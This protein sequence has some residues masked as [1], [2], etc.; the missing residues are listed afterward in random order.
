MRVYEYAKEYS[1]TA[2]QLIEDLAQGGFA[3]KSHMSVLEDEH[4]VY[5]DKKYKQVSTK[6]ELAK[7]EAVPVKKQE[8]SQNIE[9]KEPEKE[10]VFSKTVPSESIPKK[11]T[12][13]LKS[14]IIESMSVADVAQKTDL[15]VNEVILTLLRWGV[16]AT[17]NQVL[18]EDVVQRLAE[19]YQIEP[20]KP[21]I[22]EKEEIVHDVAVEGA[23][24]KERL[25]II[26]VLG[27]VDHGKTTLLDFI[28][29]TRVTSR[30]KGGITQHLGAYEATTKHGNLI[31]LDT[32]GHEAFSNI[33]KRGVK[34]A[35]IAILIVAADDGIM[36]QTIEAIKFAKSMEVPIIVAINKIDKAEKAQIEVVKRELSQHDLLP[37]EWGGD[38]VCLPISAKNGTGVDELLEMLV[39]QS[40]MMELKADVA[41]SAKGYVLESKLEK[42]RGAVATIICRHGKIKIGDYFIAGNTTGR[43]S[44]MVDSLGKRVQKAGPSIPVQVAGFSS[45]PKAGV[46]FEV[47]SKEDYRKARLSSTSRKSLAARSVFQEN[48]INLLVKTDNDSSKEALFNSINKLSKKQEKGFNVLHAAIGD[49]NEGDIILAANTGSKIVSLH[50]KIESNAA[51]LA[52]RQGVSLH[53]F[54]IIYKLLEFLEELAE[55]SK[56]VVIVRKKVGEALVLKVFNIKG[57]GVIAG[58]QVKDGLFTKDCHV[59]VWR[60]NDKIGEGKIKSLQREKKTVKEVHT[61]FECG[62]LVEGFEDFAEGDRV[63]CF[64][65]SP[66]K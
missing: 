63:E 56:E 36:P 15:P 58:S 7:K 18:P 38:V 11:K 22:D 42:G 51:L 31:F 43:V 61:G 49:I 19:H 54:D 23:D 47:V 10:E 64:L 9:A 21:T 34:V 39:L 32:P 57:V 24:L 1:V 40:Q 62:F 4:V 26:V 53:S 25:P 8:T 60:K 16:I 37:E 59:V 44:S 45:L 6:K 35:D 28:R 2:K 20:V 17:I 48:F 27:H 65:D 52:R 66:E 13:K 3:L 30:E 33:R 41:S 55:Q 50:V 14:L 12:E 29:K 5:L 46:Y